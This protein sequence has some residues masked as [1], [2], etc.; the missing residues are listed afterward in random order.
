MRPLIFLIVCLFAVPAL[1]IDPTSQPCQVGSPACQG[2]PGQCPQP[3][4]WGQPGKYV[5][6]NYATPVRDFFFGTYRFRP[7]GP[8]Q[9]YLAVPG[10][11]VFPDLVWPREQ[12][13]SVVWPDQVPT[14]PAPKVTP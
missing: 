7:S 13:P 4:F 3:W 1:A 9:P 2:C 6:K 5:P 11:V 14:V 8:P 10:K 12:R